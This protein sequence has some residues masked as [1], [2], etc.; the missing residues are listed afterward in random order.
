ML[1]SDQHTS[2]QYSGMLTA[3]ALLL[4]LKRWAKLDMVTEN[5]PHKLMSHDIPRTL[6]GILAQTMSSQNSDGSWESKLELT[7]YAVLTLAA[8]FSLP[9]FDFLKF[10]GIACMLRGKAYLEENR[11]QWRV[12]ERLWV[13]KTV[14]GSP[15][16]SQAYCLAASKVGVPPSLVSKK[17]CDIFPSTTKKKITKLEDFFSQVPAFSSCPTWKLQLSL[18]QCAIYTTALKDH[19]YDVFPPTGSS[20]NEKYQDY[21]PFTWIGCKDVLSA[22]VIP[23]TLWDMMLVSMFNFQVDAFMETVVRKCYNGRLDELKAMISSLFDDHL[24]QE[25]TCNGDDNQSATLPT[26]QTNGKRLATTD[27]LNR[28]ELNGT[29]DSVTRAPHNSTTNGN[30]LMNGKAEPNGSSQPDRDGGTNVGC[31]TNGH[32]ATNV[33]DTHDLSKRFKDRGETV[34]PILTRFIN[35]SMQHPKV[36]ASPAPIRRWLAHELLAFLLAHVTHMEDCDGLARASVAHGHITWTKP[37]TTFFN[38]VRTTSADHTSCPYS[39]VFY[40]CLV[41]EG[42]GSLSFNMQQLY[43]LEDACRHLAAMCRQYN[44]LGSVL[45]DKEERNLNSINFPE[46][47]VD[48]KDTA[49][50]EEELV[51]RKKRDLLAVAE[52]E[53]RCLDRVLGELELIMD[54]KTMEKLRLLVQVTDLYGQIYVVSDIGIRQDN[55]QCH[56]GGEAIKAL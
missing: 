51:G 20:S 54:C 1:I 3:Q 53:R 10:E 25:A 2:I 4:L 7:A 43:A 46:F 35:F 11:L 8:L 34:K 42:R 33:T 55:R 26:S 24:K 6:L 14:Y 39:F 5:I 36:L 32:G 45:R 40:L 48:D 18:L 15:N 37:R 31:T 28:K 19:R 52:Y 47:V 23:R 27:S 21:I 41:G 50:T 38:W 29:Q 16:L 9:W 17:I 49:A 30:G 44:D 56:S 22:P 12:A 13:E